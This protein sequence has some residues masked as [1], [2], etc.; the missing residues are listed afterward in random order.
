MFERPPQFLVSN[1]SQQSFRFCWKP[2]SFSLVLFR[3]VIHYLPMPFDHTFT[4][5]RWQISLQFYDNEE[6]R[7]VIATLDLNQ[8]LSLADELTGKKPEVHTAS[9]LPPCSSATSLFILRTYLISIQLR[10]EKQ[11]CPFWPPP[12]D[13]CGNICI[14]L[15]KMSSSME[16]MKFTI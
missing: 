1:I 10:T 4:N 6:Q 16:K 15:L 11:S 7:V 12:Y 14:R 5:S 13:F 8:C 2:Y 3:I 9:S